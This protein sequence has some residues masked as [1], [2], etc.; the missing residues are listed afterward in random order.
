MGFLVVV[1]VGVRY[2]F[3]EFKGLVGVFS[4]FRVIECSWEI[5]VFL[6][7]KFKKRIFSCLDGFRKRERVWD[8][9]RFGFG[10]FRRGVRR[11]QQR[12]V[13]LVGIVGCFG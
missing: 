1:W 6:Q 13:L 8:E 11:L 12:E 2:M 10:E 3:G 5:I 4:G 7:V 9:F